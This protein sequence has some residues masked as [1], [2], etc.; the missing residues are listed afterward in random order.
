VPPLREN[1]SI[2]AP[3]SSSRREVSLVIRHCAAAALFLAF[4]GAFFAACDDTDADGDLCE[5]GTNVFCRCPGGEAGTRSCNDDGDG[6][7][8]CVVGPTTPCPDRPDET[9]CVPEEAYYCQCTGADD[10]VRICSADGTSYSACDCS[11]GNGGG[12]PGGDKPLLSPCGSADECKSGQCSMGY[13]TKS[14]VT[15]DACGAGVGECVAFEGQTICRPVCK[16]QADCGPYLEPSACGY[17]TAVDATGVTVCADWQAALALPPNGWPCFPAGEE[18]PVDEL[19]HLGHSGKKRVCHFWDWGCADGC[20][21][22]T[23]CPGNQLCD[24]VPEPG[25]CY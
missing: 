11:G 6:F 8:A 22:D 13:C 19:C 14:C 18:Y 1:S 4:A 17:A 10:G 3:S 12:G 2:I 5:P 15:W 7:E 24:D 25:V 20:H 9:I 16:T 21:E 23:D